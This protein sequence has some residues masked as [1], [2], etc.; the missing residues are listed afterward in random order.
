MNRKNQ[1]AL[2]III[3]C[4]LA[5]SSYQGTFADDLDEDTLVAAAIELAVENLLPGA[6]V[7]LAFRDGD[8]NFAAHD[9]PFEM[10]VGVVF[11]SVVFVLG[12]WLFGC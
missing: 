1:F 8:D 6:E 5:A 7:E 11:E 3:A 2:S 9:L 12:V 4:T 10:C